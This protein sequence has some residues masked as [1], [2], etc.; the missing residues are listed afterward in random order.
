MPYQ[1]V[2]PPAP[3]HSPIFDSLKLESRGLHHHSF[4]HGRYRSLICSAGVDEFITII[5]NTANFHMTKPLAWPDSCRAWPVSYS[6]ISLA[7][8][9]NSNQ[10]DFCRDVI[11][12]YVEF[13][14][15]SLEQYYDC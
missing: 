2:V 7:W 10:I 15:T 8:I 6:A 13:I 12:A 1:Q 3:L 5:T 11:V 4:P 9:M 14:T